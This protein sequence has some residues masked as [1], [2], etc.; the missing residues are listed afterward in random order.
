MNNVGLAAGFDLAVDICIGR[1]DLEVN[2][3]I[4]MLVLEVY[5]ECLRVITG[6]IEDRKLATFSCDCRTAAAQRTW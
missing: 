3:D 6:P 4:G 2:R 5:P 1:S